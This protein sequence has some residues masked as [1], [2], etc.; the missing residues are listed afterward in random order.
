MKKV[1]FVVSL[2]GCVIACLAGNPVSNPTTYI[3]SSV[4][5]TNLEISPRTLAGV[6]MR[7]HTNMTGSITFS[8]IRSSVT[9][10]WLTQ[11]ISAASS[12]AFTRD[13]FDGLWLYKNDILYITLPGISSNL[14]INYEVSD[15][16]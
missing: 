16:R 15:G 1:A 4:V 13:S 8:R 6:D 10:L 12:V 2:F 9:N 5:H 7:F 14:V 3:G 11:S